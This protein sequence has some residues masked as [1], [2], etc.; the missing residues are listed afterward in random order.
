MNNILDDGRTGSS[1]RSRETQ[2]ASAATCYLE[3][4]G[5]GNISIYSEIW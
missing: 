2:P 5:N 1:L 4:K 3:K